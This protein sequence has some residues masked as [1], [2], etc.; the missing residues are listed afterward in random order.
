MI[1]EELIKEFKSF[2]ERIK[3]CLIAKNYT[4]VR[5]LDINRRAVLEKLCQIALTEKDQEIFSIIENTV[6]LTTHHISEID[7]DIK[8]LDVCTAKKSKML[9]G[10]QSLN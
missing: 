2:S 1:R 5:E 6:E 9:R 7:N 10:Y 3:R 8:A 4:A